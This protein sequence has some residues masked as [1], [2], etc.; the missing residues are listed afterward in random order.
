MQNL[1]STWIYRYI[2]YV[3]TYKRLPFG[4]AVQ[5]IKERLLLKDCLKLSGEA[6][7][8]MKLPKILFSKKD[9]PQTWSK[10]TGEQQC[11]SAI[12]KSRFVTLLKSHP[13]PKPPKIRSTSPEH[14]SSGKYLRGTAFVCQKNFK[15]LKL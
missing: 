4:F 12:S 9:A 10:P 7:I 5:L 14:P 11:R 13:H 1:G 8:I 15:T 3:N 2:H 6:I